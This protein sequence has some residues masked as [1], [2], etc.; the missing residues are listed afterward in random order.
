[1]YTTP[2]YSYFK[3]TAF[4][5]KKSHSNSGFVLSPNSLIKTQ[6]LFYIS[7]DFE[8]SEHL[9]S[10]LHASVHYYHF[11]YFTQPYICQQEL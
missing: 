8:L 7:L 3:N 9:E 4:N 6:I 5:F 10:V 1:M 2:Q 11:Y